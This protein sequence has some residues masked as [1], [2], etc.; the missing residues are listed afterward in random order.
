MFRLQKQRNDFKV[1]LRIYVLN[2]HY[3]LLTS[4]KIKIYV[5]NNAIYNIASNILTFN[6]FL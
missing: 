4:L 3:N 5:K 1:D 2:Y 6:G